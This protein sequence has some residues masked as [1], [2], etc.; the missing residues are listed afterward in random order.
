MSP[1]GRDF[2]FEPTQNEIS[3]IAAEKKND[4]NNAKI[5]SENIDYVIVWSVFNVVL[6]K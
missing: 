4:D 2:D 3:R 5:A 1:Y 6:D